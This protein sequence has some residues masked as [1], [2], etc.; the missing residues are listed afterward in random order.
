M[1]QQL[2]ADLSAVSNRY[3]VNSCILNP[4]INSTELENSREQMVF[5]RRHSTV[6]H[7]Y[8]IP[9]LTHFPRS[10]EYIHI[11]HKHA[12][13]VLKKPNDYGANPENIDLLKE[14]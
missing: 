3:D 4:F 2:E 10:H 11:P 8:I 13:V 9:W 5:L 14:L 12:F 1:S 6:D 7:L